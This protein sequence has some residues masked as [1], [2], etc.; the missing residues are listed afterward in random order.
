M[1]KS[2]K[3]AKPYR[4]RKILYP[5]LVVADRFFDPIQKEFDRILSTEELLVQ[6]RDG[7]DVVGYYSHDGRFEDTVTMLKIYDECYRRL[8]V[9]DEP[10]TAFKRLSEAIEAE[11]PL[12]E[13]LIL[14]VRAQLERYK[15]VVQTTPQGKLAAISREVKD[16]FSVAKP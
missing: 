7:K 1:A 5:T 8:M 11:G 10:D 3:P 12:S 14:E 6:D 16:L 2:K 13:S 9:N 4:P 15:K